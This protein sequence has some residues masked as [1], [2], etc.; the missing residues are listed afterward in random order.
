M[1]NFKKFIVSVLTFILVFASGFL[2]TAC[3]DDK[4]DEN[5]NQL[6]TETNVVP[7]LCS[8]EYAR[9]VY[10]EALQNSLLSNDLKI[11]G[12]N[13]EADVDGL[14]GWETISVKKNKI[15]YAKCM[16]SDGSA[17][18]YWYSNGNLYDV[19]SREYYEDFEFYNVPNLLYEVTTA[20]A[21]S[22]FNATFLGGEIV[23]GTTKVFVSGTLDGDT[24]ITITIKNNL[25]TQLEMIS[26][27]DG[28]YDLF[29]EA[30]IIYEG[31]EFP[32]SMP[33]DFSW[34]N[35]A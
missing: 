11:T 16:N 28:E 22:G 20:I 5:A 29:A 13:Y 35:R 9:G 27:E 25:I 17:D 34:Y 30:L 19:N 23:N 32:S 4:A 12:Y 8:A 26:I 10:F 7:V 31:V 14:T 33:T 1:K 24:N 2:F 3:D 21:D 18:V 6:S 15:Q